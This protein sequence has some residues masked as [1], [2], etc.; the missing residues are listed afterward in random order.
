MRC[1]SAHSL[2]QIKTLGGHG[3]ADPA[4]RMGFVFVNQRK[5]VCV[6][7]RMGV[8]ICVCVRERE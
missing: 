4:T 7:P 6:D 3:W 8:F 5:C 2:P 1:F